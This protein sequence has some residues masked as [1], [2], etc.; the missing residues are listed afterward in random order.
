MGSDPPVGSPSRR[1]SLER[2]E[3]GLENPA[4]GSDPAGLHD[5]VDGLEDV[6]PDQRQRQRQRQ[7]ART[8]RKASR[9]TAL[10]AVVA[11]TVVKLPVFAGG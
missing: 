3:P 7:T 5:H 4:L 2:W 1:F 10:R 9:L 6:I 11:W 8:T